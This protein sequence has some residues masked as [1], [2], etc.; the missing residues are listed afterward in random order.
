MQDFQAPPVAPALVSKIDAAAAGAGRG[1]Y[2]F[3]TAK[4]QILW[5]EDPSTATAF[6][7]MREATR[8]AM[9]L[10]STLRAFGLPRQSEVSAH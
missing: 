1:Q 3:V 10:P 5:V 8:V 7:S 6:P 9:R 2:L 4:G